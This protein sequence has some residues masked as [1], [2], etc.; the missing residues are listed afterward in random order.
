MKRKARFSL[1]ILGIWGVLVALLLGG[2]SGSSPAAVAP[3]GMVGMAMGDQRA[4]HRAPRVDIGLG[5]RAIDAG[6]CEFEDHAQCIGRGAGQ[7]EGRDSIAP[8]NP[9]AAAA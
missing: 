4:P 8:I 3:A 7:G 6:G 5:G 1:T 9:A 2:C